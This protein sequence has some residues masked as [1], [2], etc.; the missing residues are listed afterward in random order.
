MSSIGSAVE[1]DEAMEEI[2]DD[3]D[4][5]ALRELRKRAE[6][7]RSRTPTPGPEVRR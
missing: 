1:Q 3:I 4:D 2:S 6:S 7:R 5:A